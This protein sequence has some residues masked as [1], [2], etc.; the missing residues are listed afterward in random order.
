MFCLSLTSWLNSHRQCLNWLKDGALSTWHFSSIIHLV[1]IYI[2][3]SLQ[4][5]YDQRR[6]Y[7][8]Q[9]IYFYAINVS[10]ILDVSY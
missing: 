3:D 10:M 5:F 9:M 8:G 2:L 4:Q 6:V 7:V 1:T